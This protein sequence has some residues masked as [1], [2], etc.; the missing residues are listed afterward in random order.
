M[1]ILFMFLQI[2]KNIPNLEETWYVATTSHKD[3]FRLFNW[4]IYFKDKSIRLELKESRS[5]YVYTGCLKIDA[6][7]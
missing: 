4:L 5:L 1:G 6:T 2:W 7:I 3:C